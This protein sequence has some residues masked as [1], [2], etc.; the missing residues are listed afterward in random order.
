MCDLLKS[1]VESLEFLQNLYGIQKSVY[2]N[3]PGMLTLLLDG[4]IITKV[5]NIS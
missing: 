4:H 2:K 5:H 3:G 1:K